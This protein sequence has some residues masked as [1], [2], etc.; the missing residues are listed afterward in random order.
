MGVQGGQG[1]C[2]PVPGTVHCNENLVWTPVLNIIA[3]FLAGFGHQ[4]IV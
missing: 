3:G 1:H 2:G 4:G